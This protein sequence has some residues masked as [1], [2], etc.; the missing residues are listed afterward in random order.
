MNIEYVYQIDALFSTNEIN[1]WCIR[2]PENIKYDS[3]SSIQN[4]IIT[5]NTKLLGLK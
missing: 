5:K 3:I 4:N 1:S 2:V